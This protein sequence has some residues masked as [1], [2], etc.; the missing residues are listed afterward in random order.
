MAKPVIKARYR[1]TGPKKE[2]VS[3]TKCS[4]DPETKS[5][6]QE[7]VTEE[8]ETYMVYFPKRHMEDA[9]H[10]IRVLSFKALKELGYD[11]KPRMVDMNTGDVID[12]GGDPY[13]FSGTGIN[14][15]DIVLADDDED[16][17]PGTRKRSTQTKE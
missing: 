4:I 15:D 3:Y 14:D 17:T 2:N 16:L 6:I 9:G 8:M 12:A 13:D 11:R 5:M 10:S 1:V 7:Q